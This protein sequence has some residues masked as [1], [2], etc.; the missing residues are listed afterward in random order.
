MKTKFLSR[1]RPFLLSFLQEITL[2]TAS[3]NAD[4]SRRAGDARVITEK[5]TP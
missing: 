5:E 3:P 4:I 2:S 1:Q